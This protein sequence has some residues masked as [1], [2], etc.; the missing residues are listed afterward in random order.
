MYLVQI[1][2][3]ESKME[4]NEQENKNKNDDGKNSLSIGRTVIVL[5]MF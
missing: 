5:K 4:V 3:I 2:D 1:G